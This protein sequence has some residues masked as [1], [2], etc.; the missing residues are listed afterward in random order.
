ML[1]IFKKIAAFIKNDNGVT[2]YQSVPSGWV[3]YTLNK[4]GR[5]VVV[6]RES[7]V[8]V[9]NFDISLRAFRFEQTAGITNLVKKDR[10]SI[11]VSIGA[12]FDVKQVI[13]NFLD[14]NSDFFKDEH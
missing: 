3:D 7:T 11:Y 12:A 14:A 8:Y 10:Y 13:N 4:N 6:T 9:V 2:P 1:K 5:N